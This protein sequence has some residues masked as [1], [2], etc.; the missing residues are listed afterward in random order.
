MIY[1]LSLVLLVVIVESKTYSPIGGNLAG[2]IDWN[3]SAIYVNHLY[4]MRRLGSANSPWDGTGMTYDHNGNPMQ[5][6]GLYLLGVNTE[7]QEYIGNWSISFTG[8]GRIG[9]ANGPSI[10]YQQYNATTNTVSA[11]MTVS[12]GQWVFWCT[13]TN[14]TG[15]TKDIKWIRPG[16]DIND[17]P[18]FT[19]S[20]LAQYNGWNTF[21]FMDWFS[22]NGNG[23]VN[24]V[25]LQTRMCR[26]LEEFLMSSQSNFATYSIQTLGSTF[27]LTQL[28]IMLHKWHNCSR[29]S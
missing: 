2:A 16:Y 10:P 12:K 1:A 29:L 19:K 15:T 27:L 4:N 21:R 23:L 20:Y 7:P 25:D 28:T 3:P 17:Y 11:I 13:V 26:T 22:T 9:C 6:W 18:T 5:D 14:T 8:R 24:W